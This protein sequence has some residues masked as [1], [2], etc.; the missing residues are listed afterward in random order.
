MTNVNTMISEHGLLLVFASQAE[1]AHALLDKA[2]IDCRAAYALVPSPSRVATFFSNDRVQMVVADSMSSL[3]A[4]KRQLEKTLRLIRDHGASLKLASEGPDNID[5]DVAFALL[6]AQ[7]EIHA[8][9]IRRGI[10]RSPS[11]TGRPRKEFDEKGAVLLRLSGV[12]WRALGKTFNVGESTM[13]RRLAGLTQ[14]PQIK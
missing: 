12:S 2:G 3:G 1:E 14:G 6:D 7:S 13:R 5:L 10:R 11:R 9:A 4:T 8:K